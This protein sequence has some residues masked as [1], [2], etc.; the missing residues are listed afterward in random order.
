MVVTSTGGLTT[1]GC[2]GGNGCGGV[3][4]VDILFLNCTDIL[5]YSNY[6]LFAAFSIRSQN[7][8]TVHCDSL[9]GKHVLLLISQS[10]DVITSF[11]ST[12]HSIMTR[13]VP[14]HHSTGLK[15]IGKYSAIASSISCFVIWSSF[16]FTS[17]Y[18]FRQ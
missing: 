6:F 7:H 3:T 11:L 13:S 17:T 12:S 18:F 10:R 2:G 1:T 4:G 9:I 5:I 15:Y 14:T 8:C 16:G